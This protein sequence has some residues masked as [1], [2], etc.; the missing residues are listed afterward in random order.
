MNFLPAV[1][2]DFAQ[3]KR[4]CGAL[5]QSNMQ[6]DATKRGFRCAFRGQTSVSRKRRLGRKL[7]GFLGKKCIKKVKNK[8]ISTLGGFASLVSLRRAGLVRVADE[9]FVQA[10]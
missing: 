8:P 7:A 3:R 2:F 1:S 5:S 9:L 4:E 6:P 10:R